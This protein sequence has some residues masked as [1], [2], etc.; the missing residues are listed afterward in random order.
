MVS[1]NVR[2]VKPYA[3]RDV[4]ITA[5][6]GVGGQLDVVLGASGRKIVAG[7]G[8]VCMRQDLNAWIV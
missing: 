1:L 8:C 6:T 5:A 3:R 7:L 4:L 2:V